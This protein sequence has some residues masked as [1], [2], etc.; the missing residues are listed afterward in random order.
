MSPE[1]WA[2]PSLSTAVCPAQT[3]TLV[4][5]STTSPWLNP[6]CSDHSHGL[7]AIR[8]T[9]L[10]SSALDEACWHIF[11]GTKPHREPPLALPRRVWRQQRAHAGPQSS[12]SNLPESKRM[13]R[14]DRRTPRRERA[15]PTT[16]LT[17]RGGGTPS[18]SVRRVGPRGR[19]VRLGPAGRRQMRRSGA[20]PTTRRPDVL[21]PMICAHVLARSAYS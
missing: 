8:F 2:V 18:R 3:R 14:S 4:C 6:N 5:P 13:G 17:A 15:R 1:C 16:D 12:L 21:A 20:I 11:A 10:S 7:T 19:S 9:S